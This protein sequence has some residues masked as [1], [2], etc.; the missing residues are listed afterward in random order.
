MYFLSY[1]LIKKIKQ[2]II[3]AHRVGNV[4]INYIYLAHNDLY[5]SK[6]FFNLIYFSLAS[7]RNFYGDEFN[8]TNF[9]SDT[10]F[11]EGIKNIDIYI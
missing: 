3:N 1:T 8:I 7:F 2:A 11:Y 9:F 6:I 5:L 10:N 4:S